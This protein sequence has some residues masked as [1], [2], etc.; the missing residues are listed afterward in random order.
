MSRQLRSR[1]GV[2]LRLHELEATIMDVVWGKRLASFAVSDILDVLQKQRDIAYTTV[3]TT[4]VRLHAKGLLRRER[5]GK[6]FLYFPKMTREQFLESTA[7][8]VLDGAVG[9]QVA[10]AML[11]EKVSAASAGE[12][13]ALESLIRQRREELGE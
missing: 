7:R 11:A 5:D 9:G 8:D 13:D 10:M 1:K 6:R 4:V 12:L 3:M 2:E